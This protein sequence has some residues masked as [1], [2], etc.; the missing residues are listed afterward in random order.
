MRKYIAAS[1][2]ALA[3]VAGAGLAWAAGAGVELK[4]VEWTFT[5]PLFSYANFFG[6]YDRAAAQRGFQ[7][8]K[9]VCAACHSLSLVAYRNLQELGLS[10]AAVKGIAAEVQIPDMGEDGSAIERPGKPSDRFRKPFPNEAAARAA[11]NGAYPPDLSLIVKA[12][13]DGA[14]YLY[15]LL[16]GYDD[17]EKMPPADKAKVG[18]AS[19]W[20]LQDG[21]SFNRYYNPE[22]HTGFQ[23]AMPQ[24]LRDE[25]V[26]YTDDT[27]A[28]LDQMARDVTTFLAWAAEPRLEDRKRTGVR[29]LIFLIVLAGVML[30]VQRK[31]WANA[32]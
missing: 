5:G 26:Q 12:R 19:D 17:I 27:K 16:L 2:L 24:P 14:N 3:S 9:D 8:Y 11:N 15:S 23:I 30:A 6:T 32:H 31:I 1:A 25:Q 20:K 28:T 7:V 29:V 4:K 22:P 18:L 13:A 21:M 10:E